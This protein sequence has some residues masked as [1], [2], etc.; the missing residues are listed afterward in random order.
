M[1]KRT[2]GWI[3][4]GK[5]GNPMAE[6]LLNAG[7]DVIVFNRS[8][9]KIKS[10]LGKGARA[11]NTPA[12]VFRMTDMVFL[13]VTD[14][15]AVDNICNGQDGLFSAGVEGRIIV[16]MSTVSSKISVAIDA[17]SRA[18][19]NNYI[20]APVSGSVKQAEEGQLVIVA[21]GTS[22]IFEQVKPLFEKLGKLSLLVG[23]VG[24][25]NK[26][27]L[28]INTLLSIHAQGLA[29]AV[30]F[31]EKM[32]IE[33]GVL[34]TLLNNGALS[35]FFMKFKGEAIIRGDYAAMFSLS[36]IAK[37]LRL[38]K[39]EG[40]DF[41]L[42]NTAYATFQDAEKEFGNLDII[43]IKKEIEEYGIS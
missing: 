23:P 4:L 36:N 39:A 1:A 38:A 20:D 32:G 42:G 31:G 5:M 15:Q 35:N 3:G 19:K 10:I 22:P 26:A 28:I 6:Q 2:I 41:P 7:Y 11:A 8:K 9:E 43:A 37:D 40:L 30:T 29:E 18:K 14:D 21:G 33:P 12:D 13:M 27:K 24:A 25:G 17:A 16:N 34:L